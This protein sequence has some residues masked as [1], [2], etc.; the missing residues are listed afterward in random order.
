[1]FEQVIVQNSMPVP[2]CGCWIW[3]R[4]VSDGRYGVAWHNGESIRAHRLSYE[5]DNNVKLSRDDYV[6]HTCDVTLCVNPKHLFLGDA[7][8]NMTDKVNKDRQ[9][10][11]FSQ[12]NGATKLTTEAVSIIER[13]DLSQR[14]LAAIF[15]ISLTQVNRIKHGRRSGRTGK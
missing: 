13:S 12:K 10:R 11:N 5:L 3:M 7:Q 4:G 14:Q 8:S 6:C 1:M 15:G 2:H 9:A